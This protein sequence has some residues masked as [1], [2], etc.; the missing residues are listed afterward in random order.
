MVQRT[1]AREV[2][3]HIAKFLLAPQQQ[4]QVESFRACFGRDVAAAGERAGRS[5]ATQRRVQL[6]L[7]LEFLLAV[8]HG[9]VGP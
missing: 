5:K 6:Q 7:P 4:A 2:E 3:R 8:G 1:A 9:A